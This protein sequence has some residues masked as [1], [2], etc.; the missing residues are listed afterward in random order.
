M[1]RS[2]PRSALPGLHSYLPLEKGAEGSNT[3]VCAGRSI[4]QSQPRGRS[5]VTAPFRKGSL[6]EPRVRCVVQF[7]SEVQCSGRAKCGAPKPRL[8]Q[9]AATLGVPVGSPIYRG[10]QR[11]LPLVAFLWSPRTVSFRNR[12]EMGLDP[13]SPVASN[14]S[15]HSSRNTM[16]SRSTR[17][18]VR[19]SSARVMPSD[20][21]RVSSRVPSGR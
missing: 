5:A 4:P 9:I 18:A 21:P 16:A 15:N 7:T 12:K 8:T 17:F 1:S 20:C 14:R 3:E 10:V 13:R 19:W 11:T 6:S 2:R